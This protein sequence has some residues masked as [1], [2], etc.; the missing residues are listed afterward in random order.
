MKSGLARAALRAL[1]RAVALCLA[2]V[3]L[4]LVWLTADLPDL[5]ELLAAADGGTLVA[6]ALSAEL[7]E[8]GEL[9]ALDGWQRL[10]LG[11][12]SFLRA[13]VAQALSLAAQTPVVQKADE[14]PSG[15]SEALPSGSSSGGAI[16]AQTFTPAS[17]EEYEHAQGVYIRNYTSYDIDVEALLAQPLSLDL[18]GGEPQ[19]LIFHTHGT[20]SYA[21]DGEDVYVE[22]DPARTTDANYNVIRIGDEI[23][24]I[25]TQLGLSV[26][27][28]EGL[29]DYP[30]YNGSYTRASEIIAAYLA[31]YPSIRVV[32]DVH[33][34]ALEDEDGTIYK[35]VTEIDGVQVAQVALVMGSGS[36]GQDFPNWRENLALAARIQ[37]SMNNLYPTLARP[38]SLREARYN[39]HYTTGSL[40]VEVG[41][42]GNTLQEAIAGARL[43]ARAAAQVLLDCR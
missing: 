10:L 40:L 26:V 32:I 2:A 34:D 15:E 33:R 11:Q 14:A 25:F 4:W 6:A 42:H 8:T 39:L 30:Q 23:A 27:H 7:G 35:T 17:P 5:Q 43:F 36:G 31:A 38:I 9:D 18:S 20:E 37:Q 41:C 24:Q 22:S 28:D 29:Y 21:M 3:A 13:G 1:R 12:S 19:V 16:I